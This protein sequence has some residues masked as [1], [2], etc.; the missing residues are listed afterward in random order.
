MKHLTIYLTRVHRTGESGSRPVSEANSKHATGISTD[1]EDRLAY[2]QFLT[3]IPD[4]PSNVIEDVH[5]GG[6]I[7]SHFLL[8]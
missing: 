2:P 4:T 8:P 7:A 6:M 5:F 1:E 3:Y